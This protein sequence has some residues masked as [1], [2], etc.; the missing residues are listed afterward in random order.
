VYRL[1][2]LV[3]AG[4]CFSGGAHGATLVGVVTTVAGQVGTPGTTNST[5]SAAT[6]TM[7]S[8]LCVD[9]VNNLYVSDGVNCVIR[10]ITPAGVVTTLAGQVGVAGSM[11]GTGSEASFNS[12]AGV[13]VDTNFNLYVADNGNN[14]I[15]MITPGGVVTTLAGTAGNVGNMDGAGAAASFIRPTG[16]CVDTN[17]N[18][19]VGD[20]GN[21]EIRKIAPGGVV[22][23][24]AGGPSKAVFANPTGVCVDFGGNVYVANEDLGNSTI[25][26]VTPAGVVSTYA[27]QAGTLG[28]VDGKQSAA[29]FNDPSDV[30]VD[31]SGNVYV[32]DS[33]NN[34]VRMITPTGIVTTLAGGSGNFPVGFAG[35]VGSMDG[36]GGTAGFNPI[37]VCVNNADNL[38]VADTGNDTIRSVSIMSQVVPVIT[39][40][41]TESGAFGSL[42]TYTIAAT[43]DAF[44]FDA[45]G[46]PAGLNISRT[47][48]VI[49]GSP[50]ATG[51]FSV[52]I[53]ASN[54]AG[55]GNAT[56]LIT[57]AA[58]NG[59]SFGNTSN[60]SESYT[61]TLSLGKNSTV[62]VKMKNFN[63]YSLFNGIS[64]ANNSTGTA[65][66][67]WGIF[68]TY[69]N[70]IITLSSNSNMT[71][72][73]RVTTNKKT[74][75]ATARGPSGFMAT[76]D[77]SKSSLTVRFNMLSSTGLLPV[78]TR[79]KPT[80][81]GLSTFTLVLGDLQFTT[82]VDGQGNVM[83]SR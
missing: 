69:R 80:F 65:N 67:I 46:L 16:V 45:T 43:N 73:Y 74:G 70:A 52:T 53:S 44:Y 20:S 36:T 81:A 60:L 25:S 15:R 39:S 11:D 79:G 42:F 2:G 76:S 61:A 7:P 1:L 68:V 50:E 31:T 14:T 6:F 72:S 34:I 33:G 23:T 5:G 26:K 64:G 17:L 66:G 41:F 10:K 82:S 48:G 78:T 28:Y 38:F 35:L 19:Y 51:T 55:T 59:G 8:R 62:T 21:F 27:G 71:F 54:N 22:T 40:A 57:I 77:N 30:C 4:I 83:Y 56:L 37:G 24:L 49:T 32:A 75:I 29:R 58:G 63:F 47:T 9:T 12:P 18:V 13:C 3:L